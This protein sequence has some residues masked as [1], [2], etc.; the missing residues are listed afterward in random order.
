[1]TISP[2]TTGATGGADA[3]QDRKRV[4]GAHEFEAMLLGERM[5]PLRFGEAES[6][7]D[8]ADGGAAGTVRGMATEAMGKAIAA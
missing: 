8:D 3:I 7:D 2:V 5:K 4:A 6:S 1:M